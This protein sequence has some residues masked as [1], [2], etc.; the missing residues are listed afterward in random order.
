[1]FLY[2]SRK[3]ISHKEATVIGFV[4][5]LMS[6]LFSAV[7]G[8][9][10]PLFA[11]WLNL[12]GVYTLEPFLFPFGVTFFLSVQGLILFGF[13]L[14]YARDKKSHMMGLQILIYSLLWMLLLVI[15]TGLVGV[16][17]A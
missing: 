5:A 16:G 9:V 2:K 3:K 4:L 10:G 7:F 11:A 13:P 1:M 14:F 8:Y 15:V 6:M 17:L 12:N